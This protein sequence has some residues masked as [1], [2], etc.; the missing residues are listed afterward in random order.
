MQILENSNIRQAMKILNKFGSKTIIVINNKNK[1]IGTLS[2][3]DIRRSVIRGFDLES[4]IKNIYNKK[5]IFIYEKKI[6]KNFFKKKNSFN[7]HC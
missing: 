3:G 4:S 1:L 2:D 6:K 5:P 7:S